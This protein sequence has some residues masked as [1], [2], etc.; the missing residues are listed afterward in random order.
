MFI[1]SLG[2]SLSAT[3]MGTLAPEIWP[4]RQEAVFLCTYRKGWETWGE[5]VNFTREITVSEEITPIP[6]FILEV[7]AFMIIFSLHD[8]HA[9]HPQFSF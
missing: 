6:Y 3:A 1:T 5:R 4:K 8:M 2:V 9:T 7:L